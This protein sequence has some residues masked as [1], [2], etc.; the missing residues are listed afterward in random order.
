MRIASLAEVKTRF[1]AYVDN[2]KCFMK[3][4]LSQQPH[5]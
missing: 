2:F 5:W 4:P 3:L 1:S